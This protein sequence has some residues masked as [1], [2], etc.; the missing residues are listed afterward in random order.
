MT[1]AALKTGQGLKAISKLLIKK[2]TCEVDFFILKYR[3]S[4]A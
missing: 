3:L 4:I 1:E 2:G